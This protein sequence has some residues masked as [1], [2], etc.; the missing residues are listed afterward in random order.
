MNLPQI[1][2]YVLATEAEKFDIKKKWVV[3]IITEINAVEGIGDYTDIYYRIDGDDFHYKY[4]RK[5]S[6]KQDWNLFFNKVFLDDTE[7]TV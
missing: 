1:Y 7:V 5:I 3:G 4:V 6:Y 2:D